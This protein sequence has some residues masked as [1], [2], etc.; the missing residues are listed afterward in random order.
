M[1]VGARRLATVSLLYLAAYFAAGWLDLYTTELAL[2]RAN[3]QEGNVLATDG[4]GYSPAQAWT[5]T[6]VGAPLICGALIFGL[7]NARHV[8]TRRLLHPV[9]SFGNPFYI[10][11]WRPKVLD[12]SPLHMASF[13]LAFPAMRAIAAANNALIY[14]CGSGPLGWLIGVIA[15]HSSLAFAFWLVMG[16]IFCLLALAFAPAA[17]GLIRRFRD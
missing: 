7:R 10:V 8:A 13:A 15:K 12:R 3:A 1:I 9:R 11:P 4:T 16:P 17:A 14:C 6:L 2:R 5:I